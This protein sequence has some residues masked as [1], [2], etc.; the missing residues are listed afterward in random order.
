MSDNAKKG[1]IAILI[2]LLGAIGVYSYLDHKKQT[3][4]IDVLTNDKAEIIAELEKMEAD[5][6]AEISKNTALSSDLENQKK[7]II[8][9]KDSIRNLKNTNWNTIKFYKNKIKNLTFS[10]NRLFAKND[11]LVEANKILNFENENL[12]QEKDSLTQNLTQQTRVNDTLSKQNE[13]LSQKVAIAQEIRANGYRV[14][15]FDKR[16]NGKFKPTDKARRTNT[17][18][19]NFFINE[20]PLAENKEIQTHVVLKNLNGDVLNTKGFFTTKNKER[21]AFTES[22]IIPFKKNAIATDILLNVDNIKLEKG[23]YIIDIYMDNK[24]M[25]TLK[26]VLR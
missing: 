15:T 14:E 11:S 10:T 20:N 18:K 3:E 21:I 1:I 2:L 22:T 17:F 5:Y 6:N 16:R 9:F 25:T 13:N 23:T 7:I 4:T 24:K 8:R 12:S 26:K 19:I